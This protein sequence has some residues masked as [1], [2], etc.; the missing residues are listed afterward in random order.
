MSEGTEQGRFGSAGAAIRFGTLRFTVVSLVAYGIWA[1]GPKMG[2]PVLYPLI[3][4][5]YVGLSGVLMS[6]LLEGPRPIL[7][8][9]LIF[10]PGF[11]LYA[12][13][14]CAGWFGLGGHVG[15]VFGSAVGLLFLARAIGRGVGAKG[16]FLEVWAVL[17]LFHTL[18]YYLG[19]MLY[20][21]GQGH[22]WLAPIMDN[23]SGG[24][25]VSIARLLWGLGHGAGFGAGLGYAFWKGQESAR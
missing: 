7:R 13:G 22:E 25:R 1:F 17:F 19:D 11:L 10:V 24:T 14:W 15:E 6:G 9:Y 21:G 2:A 16:V 20:T 12:V 8:W 5:A 3:A 18:G 4:L 23:V